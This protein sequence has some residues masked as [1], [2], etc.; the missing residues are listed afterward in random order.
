MSAFSFLASK[1]VLKQK[2][3]K[4]EIYKL[5]LN[6]KT[7]SEM[8]TLSANKLLYY[9]SIKGS[10]TKTKLQSQLQYRITN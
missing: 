5:Y 1:V 4:H 7:I 3:W 9:F 10:N 2:I 8:S 6:L